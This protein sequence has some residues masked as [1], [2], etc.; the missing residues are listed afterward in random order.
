MTGANWSSSPE[1]EPINSAG[2]VRGALW[3]PS[4][5]YLPMHMRKNSSNV[6]ASW[7]WKRNYERV[8]RDLLQVQQV[9]ANAQD[10]DDPKD[11]IAIK[12]RERKVA[13]ATR[14]LSEAQKTLYASWH[15]LSPD[16]QRTTIGVGALDCQQRK[17]ANG[18]CG[19]QPSL[20]EALRQ[21]SGF[22][23]CQFWHEWQVT[24]TLRPARLAG[25]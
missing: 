16:K 17:S 5:R 13:V 23:R 2:G 12:I 14:L 21:T 8:K 1:L 9:L 18:P 6:L 20:D 3:C 11:S 15:D 25:E 10:E 19:R 7:N 22:D 24:H 4:S